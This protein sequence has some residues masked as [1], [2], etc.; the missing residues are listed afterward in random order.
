METCKDALLHRKCSELM[1]WKKRFSAAVD[2]AKGLEYLHRLVHLIIHDDIKPS[3]VR[4]DL[5]FSAKIG[6]FGLARLK[7]DLNS[8]IE[9][10][11]EGNTTMAHRG[12]LRLIRGGVR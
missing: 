5:S 2:V 7:L 11:V 12:G 4:L 8:Q 1:E 9:I 10:V 3:N 6:N